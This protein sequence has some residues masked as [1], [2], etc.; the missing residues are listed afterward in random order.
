MQSLIPFMIVMEA[1]RKWT[2][3]R[4][5]FFFS[6]LKYIFKN[7]P[8]WYSWKKCL[9]SRHVWTLKWTVQARVR[10]VFLS[11]LTLVWQRL[12]PGCSQLP[13]GTS[14]GAMPLFWS[15]AL[16]LCSLLPCCPLDY[17]YM[18]LGQKSPDSFLF[19]WKLWIPQKKVEP[20]FP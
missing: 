13:W 16:P 10:L 7:G 14:S 15:Q 11:T 4:W 18:L 8:N 6:S 9:G 17:A 12:V 3:N 2:R 19:D 20:Q 5:V 1:E